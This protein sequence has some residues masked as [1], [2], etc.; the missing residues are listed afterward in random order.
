MSDLYKLGQSQQEEIS[1][2]GQEIR[3]DVKLSKDPFIDKGTIFG[4]ITDNNDDPVKGVLIKIMDND[5]NPLYHTLTDDEGKYTISSLEPGSDYHFY[6]IKDGYLLKEERGFAIEAGQS[7]EINSKITLD[8]EATLST[9]TGHIFDTDGNPIQNMIITLLK[10]DGEE[11]IPVAITST[12]EYGQG[13]FVNVQI[14]NYIARATKQGY[15]TGVIEVKVSEPGS[16]I[17]I[18]AVISESSTESQGTING[19]IADD[20]GNPIGEA[21]VILY[22]VTGDAENP[23]YT[24]KRYS[25]T[26]EDGAYLFGN[27]P[28][29]NY[30]VKANK[31]I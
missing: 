21:V 4:T 1:K 20:E 13:I 19:V 31:E 9:I 16:I 6:A 30:I 25:R 2:V 8:P 26:S 12:N 5:H 15:E 28:K 11:E 24:P 14:G 10:I 7:L 17:N 3:L 29:G 23:I 22:E 27:V 18:D